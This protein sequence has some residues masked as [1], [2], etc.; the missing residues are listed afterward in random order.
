[1]PL[2]KIIRAAKGR[3]VM[4]ILTTDVMHWLHN[5][6]RGF[7]FIAKPLFMSAHQQEHPT[8]LADGRISH[9]KP[10]SRGDA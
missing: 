1:M 4:P 9:F 2:K 8:G 10:L 6:T 7:A 5:A 3:K